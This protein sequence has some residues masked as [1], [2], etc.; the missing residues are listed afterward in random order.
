MRQIAKE[1]G[2]MKLGS[3]VCARVLEKGDDTD[4]RTPSPMSVVR[5]YYKGSLINGKVF[6]DNLSQGYSSAFRL[7]EL[8]EGW[9]VALQKMHKGDKWLVYIPAEMGYGSW[10]QPGIPADSTL[11]FEI[12]LES[13]A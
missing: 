5:V 9:K 11:I 12:T 2:V 3:G 10:K 8:I 6:D 4:G 13:F 7:H 1:D